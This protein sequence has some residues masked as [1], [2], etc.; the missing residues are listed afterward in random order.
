MDDIVG[1]L[2]ASKRKRSKLRFAVDT[3]GTFTDLIVSG[4][5]DY[6][7]MHKAATTPDDPVRGVINVMKAAA[8]QAGASLSEYL[9]RGEILVHGT[10]HA[11]NAIITGRTARTAF[12]TTRGHPDTLVFREGGRQDA[13]NFTVPYPQ[14][15]VSKALTFEIDERIMSTGQCAHPLDEGQAIEVLRRLPSMGVEAI[16]V[17]LLWSIVNPEHELILERLIK[18]HLP[19]VPYTLS[20]RINPSIREYRRAMSTCIDASLKPIMGAYMSGLDERLRDV[21]FAGRLLVVTSQGGVID[22]AD[23]AQTPVHLI[24]S[25]PSMA[26]VGARA[27]CDSSMANTLI[28][29][30]TGGTTFDVSLIRNGRIPR[31]RETWLGKPFSSHLTGMP[32]VDIKSIGAGGG[33]I[34]WV[35]EGGLLHVGPNSA[36]AVP[37]PAA[38]GRGGDKPTVTDAAVVQGF[39]DPDN[40]LGGQMKLDVEE[41]KA[42]IRDHVG[43]PLGLRVE[44]A[45]SA[46]M[47]LATEQMVQAILDITVSQGIDPGD[48]AFVGGGGAAGL[49][50][51]AVGKR[52]GCRW[53][54]IPETGAALSAAGALVS[55]LV[56]HYHATCHTITTH[57]D[58][59]GVNATLEKLA[60]HCESF[61]RSAGADANS[62]YIDWATESRYPD[63]AWE[64]EVP[65]RTSRFADIDDVKG[66][67]A[68]FHAMHQEIFAVND[69]GQPVETIGWN[70]AVHCRLGSQLPGRI[71]L[72]ERAPQRSSRWTYFRAPGWVEA[73]VH[74]LETIGLSDLVVGPAIIQ[75]DLTSIV[76]DPGATAFRDAMGTVIVDLKRSGG[77][78]D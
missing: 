7:S 35:D 59:E 34:A 22:A 45:A 58:F 14:P 12:L 67:E 60:K 49:N 27:Y 62:S 71:K 52:L 77:T 32:S 68:D 38:Y 72:P 61:R 46:I 5:G 10:T 6:L 53:V 1:T 9:A 47:D 41:A 19:G 40:F 30:D 17:C 57:F 73:S 3:G 43:R 55:D 15:Y 42:A 26:P 25:G 70:A 44:E 36:G 75:S 13:F 65:L 54:F 16:A 31:T 48:A 28:V 66:L 63:Q 76:I 23:V 2:D 33:S 74:S 37:G 29:G 11:I 8:D 64:I 51:V 56:A 24:N 50:A 39:I 78:R 21:G 18:D 4:D 69:P 20:H